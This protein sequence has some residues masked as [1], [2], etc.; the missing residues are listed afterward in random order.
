MAVHMIV[1]AIIALAF[2][3]GLGLGWWLNDWLTN[4]P[5]PW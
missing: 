5:F 1:L 2:L 3:A 4:T